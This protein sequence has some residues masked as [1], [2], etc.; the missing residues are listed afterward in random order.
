M[1]PENKKYIIRGGVSLVLSILL[2]SSVC[3]SVAHPVR[4]IYSEWLT[5]V[6]GTLYEQPRIKESYSKSTGW[7]K[8]IPIRFKENSELDFEVSR[9]DAFNSTAYSAYI[10]DAHQGD[11]VIIWILTSDYEK[12]VSHVRQCSWLDI[13]MQSNEIPVYGLYF[14]H[15]QYMN[16][17]VLN[18]KRLSRDNS[19]SLIMFGISA[20]A[21]LIVSIWHFGQYQR[22]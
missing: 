12:R 11:T 16:L 17:R 22:S 2:A 20:L 4:Q 10:K 9:G 19:Y 8:T 18:Q 1:T 7:Y 6:K 15:A 13:L 21:L 3:Y 5:P 14:K